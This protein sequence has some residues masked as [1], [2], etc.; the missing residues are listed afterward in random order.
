VTFQSSLNNTYLNRFKSI[1][2]VRVGSFSFVKQC[3]DHKESLEGRQGDG[4]NIKFYHKRW[5]FHS[6]NALTQKYM[7]RFIIESI[8]S[9]CIMRMK[10]MK[11]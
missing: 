7:R 3:L 2:A 5:I 10:S 1:L 8:N 11:S 9:S 4:K 6:P